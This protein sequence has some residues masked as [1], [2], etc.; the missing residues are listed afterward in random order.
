MHKL[1]LLFF[2]IAYQAF[3][4]SP[5]I[6]TMALVKDSKGQWTLHISASSEAFQAALADKKMYDTEAYQNALIQFIK[7][8]FFIL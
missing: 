6:S 8:S 5:M 7:S 3:G 4:H 2:L 1:I